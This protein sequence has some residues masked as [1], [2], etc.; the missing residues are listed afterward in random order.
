ML[1][2]LSCQ[3]SIVPLICDTDSSDSLSLI[4]SEF[5]IL[6]LLSIIFAINSYFTKVGVELVIVQLV[7]MT[8]SF[9]PVSNCFYN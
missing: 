8:L 5:F 7:T 2:L 4:G 3:T 1:K 6:S 9:E